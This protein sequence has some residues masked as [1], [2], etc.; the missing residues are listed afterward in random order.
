MTCGHDRL[1]ADNRCKQCARDRQ[2][3]YRR[4]V[5]LAM[6][7]LRSI[8]ERGLTGSEALALVQNADYRTLQACQTAG[9][10]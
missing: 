2:A 4:R 8:E 6:A 7:L 5:R 1:N 10:K 3:K 9:I